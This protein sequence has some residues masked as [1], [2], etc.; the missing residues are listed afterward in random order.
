MNFYFSI[1]DSGLLSIHSG[2]I[3]GIIFLLLRVVKTII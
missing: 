3:P 1:I 2:E